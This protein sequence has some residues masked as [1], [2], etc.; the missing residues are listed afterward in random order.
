MYEML[1]KDRMDLNKGSFIRKLEWE[2]WMWNV[3]SYLLLDLKIE[4]LLTFSKISF[5]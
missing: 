3:L 4:V 2:V 5:L 1:F